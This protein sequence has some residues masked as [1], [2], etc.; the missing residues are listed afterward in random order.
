MATRRRQRAQG[1]AGRSGTRREQANLLDGLVTV[2]KAGNAA[3]LHLGEQPRGGGVAFRLFCSV[4]RLVAQR[5]GGVEVSAE[6]DEGLADLEITHKGGEME[7][8]IS[9]LVGHVDL[10]SQLDELGYYGCVVAE[11]GEVKGVGF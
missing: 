10:P 4:N 8:G 7:S 3:E 9:A 5:V 11:A 2:P 6:L 1:G